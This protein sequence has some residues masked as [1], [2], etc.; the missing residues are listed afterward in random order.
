MS[1][2]L[3]KVKKQLADVADLYEKVRFNESYDCELFK[4]H[5]NTNLLSEKSDEQVPFLS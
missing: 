3:D 4:F 2:D 5:R 1:S